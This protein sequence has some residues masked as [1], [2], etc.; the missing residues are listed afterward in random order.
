MDAD[1]LMFDLDSIPELFNDN[2]FENLGSFFD[3]SPNLR[4][5]DGGSITFAD[6]EATTI[7]EDMAHISPNVKNEVGR[8]DLGD[9][10]ELSNDDFFN[11]IESL[12]KFDFYAGHLGFL[13]DEQCGK[14]S[15]LIDS[16]KIQMTSC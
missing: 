13:G 7:V 3:D 5:D 12:F 9:I 2:Y 10:L 16:C 4:N 6:N 15:A 14:P 11:D 1:E 8:G